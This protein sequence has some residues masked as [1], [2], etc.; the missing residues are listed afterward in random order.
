LKSRNFKALKWDKKGFMETPSDV[1]EVQHVDGTV[2]Y[3]LIVPCDF[4]PMK[5]TLIKVE[6]ISEEERIAID[7]LAMRDAQWNQIGSQGMD[8]DAEQ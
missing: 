7:E 4:E 8:Q 2:D 1:L 3:D 5:P 6:K